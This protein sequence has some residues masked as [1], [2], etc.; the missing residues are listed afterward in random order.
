[1]TP[2]QSASV[3]PE[4]PIPITVLMAV[5][6]ED[7]WQ[8]LSGRYQF[9]AGE[10]RRTGTATAEDHFIAAPSLPLSGPEMD[11]DHMIW[12]EASHA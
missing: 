2:W 7:R 8:L 1:M 6:D 4:T 5:W 12:R 10:W 9:I 11:A 3:I